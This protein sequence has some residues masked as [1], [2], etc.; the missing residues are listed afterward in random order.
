MQMA[1]A[2]VHQKQETML[3]KLGLTTFK[4]GFNVSLYLPA[5]SASRQPRQS[6]PLCLRRPGRPQKQR[7]EET[8]KVVK[9]PRS[10]AQL[11]PRRR[12]YSHT[13]RPRLELRCR[14]S[15]RLFYDLN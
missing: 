6:G 3:T 1:V 11:A 12:R 15:C 13:P 9:L 2:A 14:G 10:V 8:E 7:Q 5:I 4:F